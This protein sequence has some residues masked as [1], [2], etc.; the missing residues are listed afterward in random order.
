M[1]VPKSLRVLEFLHYGGD[2]PVMHDEYT[3]RVSAK[4]RDGHGQKKERIRI[5]T[6]LDRMEA[7]LERER[8]LTDFHMWKDSNG[9]EMLKSTQSLVEEYLEVYPEALKS[10][11]HMERAGDMADDYERKE[12]YRHSN[13]DKKWFNERWLQSQKPRKRQSQEV[14]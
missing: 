1:A 2:L 10:I 14:C 12:V 13:V 9:N 8:T 6:K 3:K 11:Q 5:F 7:W 4:P